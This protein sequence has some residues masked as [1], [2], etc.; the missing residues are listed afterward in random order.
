M[1]CTWGEVWWVQQ[2]L[3]D[4]Y[5][6]LYDCCNC[7]LTG[8][9]TPFD[10]N[11]RHFHICLA[12][13]TPSESCNIS[14]DYSKYLLQKSITMMPSMSQE[15]I[16]MTFPADNA[17]RNFL[18]YGDEGRVHSFHPHVVSGWR[19]YTHNLSPVIIHSVLLHNIHFISHIK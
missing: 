2:V 10:G 9:K 15:R 6:Q 1:N 19:R 13:D 14:A 4:F 16:N 12:S 11:P 5:G 17:T 8:M 3:K 18:G 7:H